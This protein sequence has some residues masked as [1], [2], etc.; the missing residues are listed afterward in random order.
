MWRTFLLLLALSVVSVIEAQQPA[1]THVNEVDTTLSINN[2]DVF[3][4][5]KDKVV[6]GT[7]SGKIEIDPQNITTLP[8][9][10]GENDILKI[11]QLMPGVQTLGEFN[12]GMFI[13]GADTG[14]Q[15]VL[16]DNAPI[17]NPT[18]MLGFFSVFN[19][20]HISKFSLNK[21]SISAD[22]GGKLGGFLR[23][24]SIDSVARK[25]RLKADIGLISSSA[26]AAIPITKRTSVYLSGRKT[27]INYLV[28]ALSVLSEDD[29]FNVKYDFDDYNATIVSDIT[30]NDKIT[31]SGYYGTD[32]FTLTKDDYGIDG[33]LNW[34]N[35]LITGNWYHKFGIHAKMTQTLFYTEYKNSTNSY[36]G[37]VYIKLPSKL[38][39]IGYKVL[40]DKKQYFGSW[41][42]GA[43]YTYHKVNP[44]YPE[45][46][47]FM[48]GQL[49]EKETYNSHQIDAYGGVKYWFSNKIKLDA[50][51]RY[52]I[53]LHT[54]RYSEKHY[55]SN[56]EL[57]D[58]NYFDRGK[59]IK[60]YSTPE[61][62][63]EV[64]YF[65][66]NNDRAA[67]CYNYQA[68]YINKVEVLGLGFPTEFWV[69][70]SRNIPPQKAHSFAG[71][72]FGS[73]YNGMIK[74]S[75]EGFYK[76][77]YNQI[78]FLDEIDEMI[79]HKY[80][81]EDRLLFGKGK[82]YG[83]ELFL[84]GEFGD[85]STWLSYTLAWSK[86]KYDRIN[87][88]H[89]FPA[90]HDRRHDFSIVAMYKLNKNMDCSA[91]FVAATGD[92]YRV[93]KSYISDGDRY[94]YNQ[95]V[96]VERMPPYNRL[97]L[98]YNWKVLD[99]QFAKGILN[100]SLYNAYSRSNP[101][102]I[103]TRTYKYP[104]GQYTLRTFSKPFFKLLPS[105]SFQIII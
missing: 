5:Y 14:H 25:F 58:V 43:D 44:Q 2:I 32:D 39:D 94:L 51:F 17:Y 42:A 83:L 45:V 81:V 74:Y 15:L 35:L 16:Y 79:A 73:L 1:S 85:F 23:V 48:I 4:G 56:G 11:M 53:L 89:Y 102:F 86:R 38:K 7:I 98:S 24:N 105:V 46:S 33:G 26:T 100:F 3:A 66:E 84:K 37:D 71:G 78:E 34:H 104:S 52:S 22:A 31:I 6:V 12:S 29:G 65:T 9:I 61:P 63:V 72:Y 50:S 87:N 90:L 41:F 8:K 10:F 57:V 13:R 92:A 101:V 40:F 64:S 68:Q 55:D 70:A 60:T 18:H 76:I 80:V 28:D 75:A 103:W 95:N 88:G 99:N 77:L 30:K 91:T 20:S 27:Y 82:C 59:V 36:Q 21:S 97:D 49:N 54:G 67:F 19:N 69:S 93:P 47:N 96:T 62:R